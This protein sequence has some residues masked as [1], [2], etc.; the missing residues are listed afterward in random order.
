MHKTL[1]DESKQ[2]ILLLS[3]HLNYRSHSHHNHAHPHFSNYQAKTTITHHSNTFLSLDLTKPLVVKG[4]GKSYTRN[5]TNGYVSK[6]SDIFFG[7][8]SYGSKSHIF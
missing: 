6:Y 7:C 1:A 2:I 3:F 4:Y 8:L 5:L